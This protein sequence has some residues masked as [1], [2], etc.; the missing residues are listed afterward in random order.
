MLQRVG[1]LE[2]DGSAPPKLIFLHKDRMEIDNGMIEKGK[3]RMVMEKTLYVWCMSE[4]STPLYCR[5]YISCP[6]D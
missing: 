4:F 6:H 1:A 5:M 2:Q 3:G